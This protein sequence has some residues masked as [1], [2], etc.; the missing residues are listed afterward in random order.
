LPDFRWF[1]GD[2]AGCGIFMLPED[3]AE[4]KSH[5]I[6]AVVSL[7]DLNETR[8]AVAKGGLRHLTLPLAGGEVPSEELVGRFTG[9][10]RE[11][12]QAGGKTVVHCAAG[13]LRTDLMGAYWLVDN[14]MTVAEAKTRA[15]HVLVRYQEDALLNFALRKAGAL[16]GEQRANE[17]LRQRTVDWG[18]LR[19]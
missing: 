1:D 11:V 19:G 10:V 7:Q 3:V 9:F 5:G 18:K 16:S 17:A 2:L 12:A 15:K 14:G 13:T 8:E 4:L 6:A